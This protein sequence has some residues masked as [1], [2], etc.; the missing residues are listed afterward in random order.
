MGAINDTLEVLGGKESMK[1]DHTFF[2]PNQTLF[3]I[4]ATIVLTALIT[5]LVKKA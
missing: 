5:R 2:I 3:A 4:G 1:M